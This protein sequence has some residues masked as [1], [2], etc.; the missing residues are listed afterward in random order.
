MKTPITK[1]G[2]MYHLSVNVSRTS[3]GSGQK[4]NDSCSLYVLQS[5]TS[6]ETMIGSRS[7]HDET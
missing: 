5:T 3:S 1:V 2:Q 6:G 4:K 7:T